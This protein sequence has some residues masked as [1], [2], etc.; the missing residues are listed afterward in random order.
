MNCYKH[1]FEASER[2]YLFLTKE[3]LRRLK[4]TNYN[5]MIKIDKQDLIDI[6]DIKNTRLSDK[7]GV[8]SMPYIL[9][10]KVL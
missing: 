9:S 10:T 5:A 4:L 7:N 2:K 3:I 1:F 6:I 8:T